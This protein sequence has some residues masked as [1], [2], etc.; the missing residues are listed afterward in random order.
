MGYTLKTIA[1]ASRMLR[2]N[3]YPSVFWFGIVGDFSKDF[4]SFGLLRMASDR[5]L[6]FLLFFSTNVVAIVYPDFATVKALL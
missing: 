4:A 3:V 2:F 6:P 1:F 5:R